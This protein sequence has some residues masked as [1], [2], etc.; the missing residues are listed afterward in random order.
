MRS[1]A[2]NAA[3]VPPAQADRALDNAL[4]R[5][6]DG[7]GGPPGAIAM[8]H[9]GGRSSAHS[10][11]VGVCGN[12]RRSATVAIN[13]QIAPPI[14]EA[15]AFLRLRRTFEAAVCAALATRR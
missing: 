7:K 8:V 13:R 11:G 15:A 6:V 10:A 9:R 14:G 2:A 1:P 5:L 4:E 3:A 12:G